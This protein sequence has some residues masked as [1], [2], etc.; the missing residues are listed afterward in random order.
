MLYLF[1]RSFAFSHESHHLK[2][3]KGPKL[4]FSC[5]RMNRCSFSFGS[6]SFV[7]PSSSLSFFPL[8]SEDSCFSW[9]VSALA[10]IFVR[11]DRMRTQV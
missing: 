5:R 1:P 7:A 2:R 4:G 11:G 6:G 3:K 8:C 10:V 9:F